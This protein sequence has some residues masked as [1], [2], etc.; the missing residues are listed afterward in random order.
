[1]MCHALTV[2]VRRKKKTKEVWPE[3]SSVDVWLLKK[4]CL[5]AVHE[6]IRLTNLVHVMYTKLPLKLI[7]IFTRTTS[8]LI[9]LEKNQNN[10]S[11]HV[12]GYKKLTPQLIC[13]KFTSDQRIYF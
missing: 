4:L 12:R 5:H 2:T 7:C 13:L 6:F 1:M 10:Q 8:K 3:V 9:S 11:V